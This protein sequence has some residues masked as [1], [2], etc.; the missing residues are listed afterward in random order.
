[1]IQISRVGAAAPRSKQATVK[2]ISRNVVALGLVSFLTDLASEMLYPVTPLFL[3]SLPGTSPWMLGLVEGVAEGV[4]S[5]LRWLGGALS[6]R[7]RRRKPFVVA[8]YGLSAFSKPLIGLGT[9]LG[10]WAVLAGRISDRFGKSIRTSARDALI[11]DSTEPRY[12]GRAF[13]LHRSMDTLGAILGPLA[14]LGLLVAMVG[15]PA[16]FSGKV[17]HLPLQNLFYY[18]LL[19]GLASTLLAACAVGEVFPQTAPDSGLSAP[20]A[21]RWPRPFLLFLLA[22][23]FFSLANS[24]DSFLILRAHECGLSFGHVILAFALYNTVYAVLAAPLGNCS[25]VIGRKAILVL[26]YVTY[27]LV[28]L[29]FARGQSFFWLFAAYG[30]YQAATEG[31]GKAWIADL[32]A[33]ERRAEAMGLF[34]T[35]SGV[36]QLIGSLVTGVLWRYNVAGLCLPFVLSSALALLAIPIVLVA[37]RGRP[38]K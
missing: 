1:M 17:G 20:A 15:V 33:A 22:N 30:L 29:G 9:A 13:G 8:G 37:G 7:Y 12:R 34:H 28:Y 19:P 10:W 36:F 4:S 18:A 21:A 3:L 23:A 35:V 24:S 25:D 6:D 27:A 2:G 16:A 38:P 14:T 31:I 32:V 26:G 5:G 11:A